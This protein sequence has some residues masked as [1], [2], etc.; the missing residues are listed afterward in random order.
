MGNSESRGSPGSV[1][2]TPHGRAG[3]G[4]GHGG[5]R[6]PRELPPR[7]AQPEPTSEL[8]SRSVSTSG[9]AERWSPRGSEVRARH[10]KGQTGSTTLSKRH[11]VQTVFNATNATGGTPRPVL[12]LHRSN[13]C[14]RRA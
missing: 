11:V 12:A 8:K 14:F 7:E 3:S 9:G 10:S 5:A 2:I 13:S 6:A 4:F 1:T